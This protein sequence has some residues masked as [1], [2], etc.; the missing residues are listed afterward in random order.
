MAETSSEGASSQAEP[1]IVEDK[2]LLRQ[3]L[4]SAL[5]PFGIDTAIRDAAGTIV[6][7]RIDFVNEELAR[8]N[9]VPAE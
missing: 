5:E 7:F 6:D 2:I 1:A 4:D 9:R 3:A 8:L